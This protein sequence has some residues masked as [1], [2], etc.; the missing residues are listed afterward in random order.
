MTVEKN[1]ECQ[2]VWAA[3]CPVLSNVHSESQPYDS[4]G[5]YGV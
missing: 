2:Q 5:A 3:F 4:E 1:Q